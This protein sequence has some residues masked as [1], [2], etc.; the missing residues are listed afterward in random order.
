[1]RQG[2]YG[3]WHPG[4]CAGLLVTPDGVETVIG[5]AGELHP[6]V[7][8]AMGLPARTSAM[9]LDLDRLSAAGGEALQA[10]RISSSRWRPRT[11]R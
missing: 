11:W 10:P 9:E 1:M 2:Q 3:P 6:R 7:V 5:H 8:K 4:R